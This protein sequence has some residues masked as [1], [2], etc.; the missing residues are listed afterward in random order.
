MDYSI[1][2]VSYIITHYPK[3][4]AK[5]LT[6]DAV[7]LD[8]S[9][10][11]IKELSDATIIGL[12]TSKKFNNDFIDFSSKLNLNPSYF[13]KDGYANGTGDWMG[14]A[15]NSFTELVTLNTKNK[16]VQGQLDAE[17]QKNL[18]DLALA[19]KDLEKLKL[20][21]EG[22]KLDLTNASAGKGGNTTLY[23]ALGIGGVLILGLTIFLVTRKKG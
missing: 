9:N 19:D 13:E 10:F 15:I 7:V 20:I 12:K 3:E 22:K 2:V 17:N 1:K 18:T 11:S 4:I 6:D 5:L 21:N 14:Q 16:Q 23:I 8:A